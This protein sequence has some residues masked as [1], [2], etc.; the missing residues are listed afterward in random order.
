M[1]KVVSIFSFLEKVV[2][3][4]H[5]QLWLLQWSYWWQPSLEWSKA[6][7]S[8]GLVSSL[9]APQPD[10]RY[11]GYLISRLNKDSKVPCGF[12]PI[13]GGWGRKPF[14]WRHYFAALQ[15]TFISEQCLQSS[16]DPLLVCASIQT[17]LSGPKD[18]RNS[19]MSFFIII[20]SRKW[21]LK[22]SSNKKCS[23]G[24]DPLLRN[25][26]FP[27]VTKAVVLCWLLPHMWVYRW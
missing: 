18:D 8:Q 9:Q 2:C 11:S 10:W 21:K 14:Q 1:E 15:C 13:P 26:L 17:W 23:W 27:V 6:I 20:F 22:W 19:V 25:V 5:F 24:C 12:Q 7:V 3:C 4:F 16:V